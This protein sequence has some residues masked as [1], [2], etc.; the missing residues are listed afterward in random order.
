MS[1]SIKEFVKKSGVEIQTA[2]SNSNWNSNNN[3]FAREL[4]MEMERNAQRRRIQAAPAYKAFRTPPRRVVPNPPR[5]QIQVPQRLQQNLIT[6][7][8]YEPLANEFAGINEN[9]LYKM[10]EETEFK[11]AFP[12][13]ASPTPEL[14]ISKLNPGMF[15]A[16]VD[17]GFSS[18]DVV[19]DLKKILMKSPVGRTS[20]GEG[21]YLD[22]R[23]I[24]GVYGQFQIGFSHTKNF[25]PKG[26]LNKQF[27]S[28]KFK[29]TLSNDVEEKGCDVNIYKNGKIRFSSGFIGTNISNQPELIRRFIVEKYTDKQNF[30]YNPFVYNNLS[31]QFR[32]NGAFKMEKILTSGSRYGITNVSYEPEL[33]PFLYV[34][35]SDHKL[36]LSK[37]GNVQI[38]GAKNPRDML[39]GYELAK[40][41]VQS[42]NADKIIIVTGTFS[43]GVKTGAGVKKVKKTANKGKKGGFN[44]KQCDRMKLPELM[45]VARSVGIVNFR[46]KRDGVSRRVTKDVLC[47]RIENAVGKKTTFKNTNKGKNVPVTGNKN[48]L[49]IGRELC[50]NMKLDEIKRVAMILK[51]KIE[52][53]DKKADLC[54]KIEKVRNNI[55]NAPKP[56]SPKPKPKPTKKQLRQNNAIAKRNVKKT[57][58]IKK[59]GLDEVSIRK[60]ITKLYGKKWMNRYNP[61]INK[62]VRN[63]KSSL[64]A[65]TRGNKMG[66]PFKKNIDDMKKRVVQQWKM[67]RKRELE[68]VYLMKSVNIT[69]IPLNLRNNYR[70][71]AAE[72]IMSK[73]TLPSNK[74]LTEYRNSWLKFRANITNRNANKGRNFR[75]ASARIE[76]L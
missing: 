10:L 7:K 76:K 61:N 70:R 21:L 56:N 59:R 39:D 2:D 43:K 55:R 1:Q 24:Q 68:K 16:N 62:D 36:I 73:K 58:V 32:V 4:E 60:D 44:T 18:K 6:N 63:M 66:V 50:R 33:S 42:L 25:G 52:D 54:L 40:K 35:F 13:L 5:S 34:Y 26:N 19:I 23:E 48:T 75:P 17:S 20:I 15:N 14:Q 37:S 49:R 72:Y 67:E 64:N 69:G 74:M 3:N 11:E 65:I 31:G 41:F 30:L 45:N 29:L 9:A 57:E 22:T 47:K 28:V 8:K 71:A 12:N 51:I 38:S 53:K 46:M 27:A